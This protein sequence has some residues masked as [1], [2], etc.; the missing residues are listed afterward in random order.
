MGPADEPKKPARRKPRAAAA[1][2]PEPSSGG[3]AEAASAPQPRARAAAGRKRQPAAEG[4]DQAGQQQADGK[5]VE[6]KSLA[7]LFAEALAPGSTAEAPKKRLVRKRRPKPADPTAGASVRVDP[8]ARYSGL[9]TPAARVQLVNKAGGGG[10]GGAGG[11]GAGGGGAKGEQQQQA[12]AQQ[13]Q[14]QQKQ[15]DQQQQSDQQQQQ[16]NQKQR[17][18]QQQSPARQQREAA[19]G[20]TAIGNR[21]RALFGG[22]MSGG[23]LAIQRLPT[24]AAPPVPFSSP[25]APSAKTTAQRLAL[26]LMQ[27]DDGQPPQQKQK[28]PPQ[29]RAGRQQKAGGQQQ[30][31]QQQRVYIPQSPAT[32]VTFGASDDPSARSDARSE[33]LRRMKLRTIRAY[34]E[35]LT[36]ALE[37]QADGDTY[38]FPAPSHL[39]V[40]VQRGWEGRPEPQPLAEQQLTLAALSGEVQRALGVAMPE[41]AMRG[42]RGAVLATLSPRAAADVLAAWSA[43]CG[44][45]YVRQLVAVEPSV[46]AARPEDLLATLE[47]LNQC[48]GL[49]PP[50][51]VA[52]VL[53][54]PALVGLTAADMRSRLQGLERAVGLAPDEARGLALERPELLMMREYA[55]EQ[56]M[57]MLARLLPGVDS[58]LP[59]L[60]VRR[61]ILLLRSPRAL[62]R[63]IRQLATTLGLTDWAAARLVASGPSVL[64]LSLVTVTR[65]W[66]PRGEGLGC[67]LMRLIG[68]Q[69]SSVGRY[70]LVTTSPRP[71]SPPRLQRLKELCESHP[72]WRQQL[73]AMSPGGLGRCLRCADAVLE[74]LAALLERGVAGSRRLPKVKRILSLPAGRYDEMLA[75][76]DAARGARGA[77]GGGGSGSDAKRAAAEELLADDRGLATEDPHGDSDEEDDAGLLWPREEGGAGT[78]R[79]SPAAA[80]PVVA[81]AAIAFVDAGA[82]RSAGA[83]LAAVA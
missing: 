23:R 11:G 30:Q 82:G 77:E 3:G 62:A 39:P 31:Q 61:P 81:A 55:L 12:K 36:A 13:G 29:Q 57:G 65:R 8:W 79:A 70:S 50:A 52:Y 37:W 21:A 6:V 47:A 59:S 26:G 63:D 33:A 75:G 67:F 28:Q 72:R 45:E 20:G 2:A 74:R 27:T 78:P 41:R 58:R 10:G 19:S 68:Q 48:G 16:P 17:R 43:V 34:G 46:M 32:G 56:R 14:Q 40:A 25:R 9:F 24:G 54:H 15:G 64:D 49:D 71:P 42:E 51:A 1:A 80:G 22:P 44:E 69:L 60:V 73:V 5:Q 35:A 76:L 83:E 53:R 7:A 38:V 66:G 18:Q 4:A